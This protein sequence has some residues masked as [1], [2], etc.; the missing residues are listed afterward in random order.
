LR[1]T[2]LFPN[3]AF[4]A[5]PDEPNNLDA[6]TESDSEISLEWDEVDDADEYY[7][8]RSENSTHTDDFKKIDTTEDTEYT[9]NDLDADTKYYY[10]VKAH[11]DEGTSGY[12]DKAYATTGSG[13]SSSGTSNRLAGL[14]RYATAVEIAKSGWSA[15]DYAIIASGEDYPDAL[16]G[17]P[18]AAE[19]NAPILLTSQ[20]YLDYATRNQLTRLGVNKVFLIGGTGVISSG[21]ENTLVNMGISVTR[22]AGSDRY[23]T[24][25]KVAQALGGN[26]QAVIA[27]GEDFPDALSIAPIAGIKGIPILLTPR[28]YLPANVEN[29]LDNNISSTY[30][31]GGTGAISDSVYRLLPSPQRYSGQNRYETNLAVINA[32]SSILNFNSCYLATGESFPDAL[33]GSALASLKKAPIILVS[34]IISLST[35]NLIKN[36]NVENVIALG[37]TGAVSESVLNS[38]TSDTSTPLDAPDNLDATTE[39]DSEIS[40][41]WDEVDDTDEYYIYRSEDFFNTDDF[42]KIDTTEDTEYT[43]NDLDAD[44][45]Y[46]Y[47]VKAHNDNATSDYSNKAYATTDE[48]LDAPDDLQATAE[49]NKEISLE[50]DEVD[51]ADEYHIYRSENSTDNDDFDRIATIDDTEYTDSDLNANTKY[52]YM[53]KAHNDDGTSNFSHKVY[54]TTYA[55]AAPANLSATAVSAAEIDLTWDEVTDA[56]DYYIFRSTSATTGFA[57]IDTS[58]TT[59]Y[60]D[61]DPDLVAGTTYY[62][63]LKAH[64][65]DGTS[66]CE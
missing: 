45:K 34:N 42:E 20:N 32:F 56:A 27:T 12:S 26:T 24:S 49:S 2:L 53:L 13:S 65:A 37:G 22:L 7:I 40:L 28:D 55:L 61:T 41:E 9:D 57:Q 52:Y 17:A 47:M 59:D 29:Y 30:V 6:T 38:L 1:F 33:T 62:Y 48:E 23:E 4:A 51:N 54:A 60:Q 43:D 16:C 64:N 21:V 3:V 58:D 8:Y 35:A 11:N 36:K 15:S 18:L 66:K 5:S 63:K 46:Y 14:D 31:I 25:L 10:M 19:Y 44:T 50:W 39:S